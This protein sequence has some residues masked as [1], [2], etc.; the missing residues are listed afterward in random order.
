[1]KKLT[2]PHAAWPL[3]LLLLTCSLLFLLLAQTAFSYTFLAGKDY[4]PFTDLPFLQGFHEGE[5][6]WLW[7]EDRYRYW[8]WSRGESS[9]ELPGVGQREVAVAFNVVSHRGHWYPNDA[10]PLLKLQLSDGLTIPLAL[11]QQPSRYRLLIPSQALPKGTLQL[12]FSTPPWQIPADRRE[13]LGVA[14]GDDFTISSL[15][16]PGLVIPDLSLLLAWSL[17][18]L[19]L[20]LALRLLTFSPKTAFWMLLPLA[21]GF[22]LLT[23]LEAPRLGWGNSW[24]WEVSLLSLLGAALSAWL[25]PRLLRRLDAFP[26]EEKQGREVLRW[27]SLLIVVSF[28]LKYGGRLYPF[29]MPGDLQLHVNRSWATILGHVHILAQHRGLPFP[30]PNG[31]YFILA[32]FMLLGLDLRPILEGGTA[33]YEATIPLLLYLIPMRA[34]KKARLGLLTAAIYTFTAGGFMTTWFAFHTQVA[35]QWFSLL[36]IAFLVARWP[37]YPNLQT[38]LLLVFLFTQVF[39]GHIG[40]F[41]NTAQVGLLIVPLLWWRMTRPE[42]RQSTLWL[43]GA[44]TLAATFAI[45]GYYSAFW[46]VIQEQLFGA[47]THG[48]N[49]VT[50]RPPIPRRESLHAL[51]EFGLI[52][53]FGFFPIALAI[54]GTFALSSKKWRT[55]LVPPLVWLT[56]LVS[57]LQASL[58]FITL[59]SITTRWLMFSAWGIALTGALGFQ[60]FW[61]RGR[62]SRFICLTMASYVGWLTFNLWLEA[63]A[64]RT[65]PIE[66]F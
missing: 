66:P 3:A 13:A 18:L 32:P 29:S 43:L 50:K 22:P 2:P 39:L 7:S 63:M 33:L 9:L 6:E 62:T 56:F 24:I 10:P 4:G 8:R 12:K 20:W 37:R 28:A 40:L 59:N 45:L 26:A 47:A 53:H 61:Q 57:S 44:G 65:V 55:S 38:W 64:L 54:P 31:P 58:P 52:T 14:L 60:L 41:I 19:P 35:A 25:L 48:L 51:W 49:E 30:F 36:L 21:L 17:S 34:T 46:S 42:E 15:T 27:L 1:M 5:K 16:S 11:R 23:L